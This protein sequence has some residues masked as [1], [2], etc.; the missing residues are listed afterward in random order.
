MVNRAGGSET[1]GA[2]SIGLPEL[3]NPA[4]DQRESKVCQ[5]GRSGIIASCAVANL[6]SFSLKSR[7]SDAM[8][9]A[10]SRERPRWTS[11]VYIVI[12][13]PERPL[14]DR[15]SRTLLIDSK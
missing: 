15:L 13:R 3:I 5:P 10:S 11:R 12:L 6:R 7:P 2:F 14:D 1:C 8:E 9:N 4:V